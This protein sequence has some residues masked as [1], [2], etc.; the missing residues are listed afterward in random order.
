MGGGLVQWQSLK[1]RITVFTL[2]IFVISI[3]SLTLYVTRM[4]QEDMERLLGEQQFSTVSFIAA[5]VNDELVDRLQALQVVAGNIGAIGLR[6][7]AA[8]QAFLEGRLILHNLFNGGITVFG[9]DGT[10]IADVPRS[11]GRIGVN[12]MDREHIAAALKE[13]K[14]TVGRPVMGR[15]LNN[16]LIGVAAPIRDALGKVI[17]ALGGVIDLASPNFL[18]KVTQGRYGKSGGYLLVAPQYRM[19][20]TATD[21]SRVMEALPAPGINLRLDRFVQ[22]YEGSAVL[23]NPVGA[24]VL[25]S[26]KGIPVTG[27]YT[28]VNIPTAEAFAPIRDMQRRMLIATTLLTLLAGALTWWMV[29]RELSPMIV[30]AK[31]LAHRSASG[32]PPQPLPIARPDEIGEL[33]GG[34]NRLLETLAQRETALRVSEEHLRAI[35]SEAPVGIAITDALTHRFLQVNPRY[36]AMV[37][38][39]EDE[40]LAGSVQDVTHPEDLQASLDQVASMIEAHMTHFSVDKRYVKPDG[41]I[42]WGA[43]TVVRMGMDAN[44][45]TRHLLIVQD[46]TERKHTEV[47]LQ[48]FRVAMDATSDGIY[49][50]DR[51]SMRY[52]D[53]NAGACRMRGLTREQIFAAGPEG[54]QALSREELVRLYDSVIATDGF[55]PPQEILRTRADG[56]QV[57][58]E[59]RRQAQRSGKDWMIVTVTRDITERKQSEAALRDAHDELER[60]VIERTEQLRTLAIKETLIEET[61]RRVIADDLHDGLGQVLHVIRLQLD[62]LAKSIPEE[63]GH[64]VCALVEQV[65]D[66]SRLVRSLISELSPPT[67]VE[68]GPVAAFE[69]LSREME[70]SYGLEVILDDDGSPPSLTQVLAATL[71]RA[72]RELLINVAKHANTERA[73]ITR[74]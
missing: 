70:R 39:S 57:W 54:V 28:V 2:A 8:A 5:E 9:L 38:R 15:Q 40:V 13:G 11:T 34:F 65:A 68:I 26:V 55:T 67:L 50:I 37:G 33:I 1:T 51:A 41:T 44:G 16:P 10:A 71:Y 32:E 17:G 66:A 43:L 27:W 72:V 22:G 6:N 63:S 60:R 62:A 53:I 19:I 12:Y 23:V 47:Q 52:V 24:E 73:W 30:A 59:H 74:R 36:C 45:L 42:V 7:T 49:V 35:F 31:A 18:D 21:K 4:L 3:W 58:V 48:R 69:W 64:M 20:V 46:I 56:T 61:E 29:R 14:A 25:S